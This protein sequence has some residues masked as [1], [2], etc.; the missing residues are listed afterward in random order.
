MANTLDR[1]EGHAYAPGADPSSGAQWAEFL[2]QFDGFF[3]LFCTVGLLY[4]A[5]SQYARQRRRRKN[6][7]KVQ[8]HWQE[9]RRE[10]QHAAM[11]TDPKL[12]YCNGF[13]GEGV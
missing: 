11:G 10:R 6:L 7:R 4:V 8:Q 1:F 5:I 9:Q 3:F 13:W 2:A 12:R